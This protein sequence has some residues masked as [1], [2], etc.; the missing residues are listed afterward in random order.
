[1]N[2]PADSAR[3]AAIRVLATLREHGHTA[4]LAGGCVRDALLGNT[5][6]DYDVATDATP[7]VVQR[8]FPNSAAVGAAFGV[9][10]VY[11]RAPRHH[12]AGVHRW[13][14]EVAT[15]RAETTYSDG[16][17]P[18]AVRFTTAEQ[19]AKRRDFTINGLF[20]DPAPPGAPPGQPDRIIDFVHGRDDLEAGIIRAIGDPAERFGEDYLRMLR[21]IRFAARLGFAIEPKTSAAIRANARY[22]G[23]I[24]RERI[25]QELIAMLEGTR[26]AMALHLLQS[27][28]LDGPAL[29]ED[30]ADIPLPI[31]DRL[32]EDARTPARLAAWM[33]DRL[34]VHKPPKRAITRWRKALSLSNDHRDAMGRLFDVLDRLGRWQGATTAERKRL[35]AH[36]DFD[37][38]L[39]LREAIAR[40]TDAIHDQVSALAN[41]GV[42]LAP[43]P[44]LTGDDL[45]AKGVEPGPGYKT[46]LDRAYDL[47][48][49]GRLT[50]HDQ[51]VAWLGDVA[52][53]L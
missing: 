33:I 29:N 49:E 9:V 52:R 3:D 45:I 53:R 19:D 46:L 30:P 13:V 4:Y 31:T 27:H 35:A 16:R 28:K 21:A 18:D 8:L 34:C 37:Q 20:A 6:K 43:P 42:G 11:T 5:P 10:I 23:Q 2:Q 22:L 14:T 24:S 17:R 7:A 15:F 40:D 38:A 51:A 36:R 32:S 39:L 48:L 26:P 1:M 41:D 25:G 44:L 12:P 50:T 47:Q